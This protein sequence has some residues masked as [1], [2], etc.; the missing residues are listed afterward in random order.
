M[1][2]YACHLNR[3]HFYEL[4]SPVD[5]TQGDE[6]LHGFSYGVSFF[7]VQ[8][9][10]FFFCEIHE[11]HRNLFKSTFLYCSFAKPLSVFP[12]GT[13]AS[14]PALHVVAFLPSVKSPDGSRDEPGWFG[15]I[16]AFLS[17]WNLVAIAHSTSCGL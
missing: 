3:A 14:N 7:A 1:I 16:I 8:H 17:A 4:F 2:G 12:K 9:S 10:L 6:Y 15:K 13:V 5:V 11:H